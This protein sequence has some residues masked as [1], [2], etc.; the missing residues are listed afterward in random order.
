MAACVWQ[1]LGK[2]RVV[3]VEGNVG[4]IGGNELSDYLHGGQYPA[5]LRFGISAKRSNLAIKCVAE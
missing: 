1:D 3:I 2:V 4:C 5:I